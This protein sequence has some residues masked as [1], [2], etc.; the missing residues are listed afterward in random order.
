MR[1]SEWEESVQTSDGS[2]WAASAGETV[3]F[4]QA[5]AR[6]RR[7]TSCT[8]RTA[9]PSLRVPPVGVIE[10]RDY[11]SPIQHDYKHSVCID[12]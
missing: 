3:H 9:S 8:A 12:R 4:Q 6:A 5:R 2:V 10:S 1:E 11:S 7:A